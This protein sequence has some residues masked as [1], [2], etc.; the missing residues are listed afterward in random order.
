MT[1]ISDIRVY[2]RNS[3]GAP[4]GMLI[5]LPSRRQGHKYHIGWSKTKVSEDR[6]IKHR[7]VQIAV[8]RLE[9]AE[10]SGLEII[11]TKMPRQIRDA[12]PKFQERCKRYFK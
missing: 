9:A 1:A 6:F 8:G 5:A 7:A 12:L 11:T 10:S 2:T 4:T 3:M